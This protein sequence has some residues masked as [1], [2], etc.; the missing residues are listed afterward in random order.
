VDKQ[1]KSLEMT[2]SKNIR[3]SLKMSINLASYISEFLQLPVFLYNARQKLAGRQPDAKQ[4]F[5]GPSKPYLNRLCCCSFF[6]CLR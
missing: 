5:A 1:T 3:G 6:S 2:K 4:D